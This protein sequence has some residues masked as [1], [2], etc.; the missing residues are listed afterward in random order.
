MQSILVINPK[1]VK[2]LT[3]SESKRADERLITDHDGDRRNHRQ[4][5]STDCP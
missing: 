1:K 3:K 2:F 4:A 5:Q